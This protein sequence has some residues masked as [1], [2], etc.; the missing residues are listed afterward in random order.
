L[1]Q[2]QFG[3]PPIN[4]ECGPFA[5]AGPTVDTSKWGQQQE[6]KKPMNQANNLIANVE[7][8]AKSGLQFL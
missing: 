2:P 3:Q 7:G 4:V 5:M 6:M 8:L 1:A